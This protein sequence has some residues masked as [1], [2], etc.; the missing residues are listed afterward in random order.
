MVS[1]RQGDQSITDYFTKLRVIWDELESY[2]PYP[3]CSCNSKCVCDAFTS[4]MERKQQDHVMQF[5][6]GLN[7]QFS[8][9]RSNVLT[10]D[11]LPNISKVFSYDV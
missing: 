8:I 6:R 11:P 2:K 7:D 10:M 4:V 9:V 5:L 1:T 3:T